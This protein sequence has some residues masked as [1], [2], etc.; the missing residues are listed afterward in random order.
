MR[1]FRIWSVAVLVAL[2]SC[3][4]SV[5]GQSSQQELQAKPQA[6]KTH[7]HP[8][9]EA[10]SLITNAE[11]GGVQGAKI[12]DAKSSE[13]S[14]GTYLISQ[15]YYSS[16]EPNMS[17]SFT[18]T[19]PNPDDPA[20]AHPRDFWEKTFG[21]FG[22]NEREMEEK[23]EQKGHRE[24]EEENRVPPKPIAGTGEDAFWTGNRFGGALYVLKKD[25]ILRIS[26]GGPDKEEVKINKS[27]ALAEKA[28]DRLQR[29]P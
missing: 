9:L 13:T 21:K 10:C 19:E 15:C 3:N 17:V 20:G 25:M 23:A 26:V 16:S 7:S 27:K 18:L 6:T 14:D 24:E 29:S 1:H 28:M 2:A 22:R 11:V 4:K 5:P 8:R 12:V